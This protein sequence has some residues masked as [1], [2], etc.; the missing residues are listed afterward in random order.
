MAMHSVRTKP[1]ALTKVGILPRGLSL[2]YESG[3]SSEEVIVTRS[4]GRLAALATARMA[5]DRGLNLARG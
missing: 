4:R 5:V 3:A 1:L 2:R